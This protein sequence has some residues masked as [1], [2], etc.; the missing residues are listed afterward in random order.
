M[1]R[2]VSDVWV[3]VPSVSAVL[4]LSSTTSVFTPVPPSTASSEAMPA[5]V[6]AAFDTVI[7]SLPAPPSTAV[8][9]AIEMTETASL[10]APV[11]RTVVPGMVLSIANESSPEPRVTFTDSISE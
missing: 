9:P 8:G 11:S 2:P 5:V 3:S 4:P 7:V 1:S 10:P 6:S